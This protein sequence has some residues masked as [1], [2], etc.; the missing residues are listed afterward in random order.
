MKLLLLISFFIFASPAELPKKTLAFK[1]K[2]SSLKVEVAD[3]FHSRKNGLM[4]RTSLAPGTGMLFVFEYPHILNF[5]MKDTFIPLSIGYFDENK[6]LKEIH[7]MQ[8]QKMMEREQDLKNYPSKTKCKYALEV[9]QG[10]FKK[11]K[12]KVGDKFILK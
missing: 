11:N 12:I 4:N 2:K 6:V 10:W 5:W 9:N 8:P 1:G 7:Q 3:N